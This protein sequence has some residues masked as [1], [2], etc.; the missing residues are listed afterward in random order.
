M[1]QLYKDFVTQTLGTIH[2]SLE[3][4]HVGRKLFMRCLPSEGDMAGANGKTILL[5]KRVD[6]KG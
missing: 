5:A 6:M 2:L 4:L 1:A 3:R